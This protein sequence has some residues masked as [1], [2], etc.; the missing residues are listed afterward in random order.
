M[1]ISNVGS[2]FFENTNER[3]NLTLNSMIND[4]PSFKK[5]IVLDVY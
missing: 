3:Q 4:Q 2:F 1:Q 5:F